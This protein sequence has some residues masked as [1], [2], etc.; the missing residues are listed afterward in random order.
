VRGL[1]QLCEALQRVSWREF[2]QRPRVIDEVGGDFGAGAEKGGRLDESHGEGEVETDERLRV[3]QMGRNDEGELRKVLKAQPDPHVCVGEVDFGHVDQ[4]LSGIDVYDDVEEA[5]E[6]AV[7]L[8]GLGRGL[9]LHS[10]IVATPRVVI[11]E[12][13]LAAGLGDAADRAKPDPGEVSGL[14]PREEANVPRRNLLG[15]FRADKVGGM[16]GGAVA[17]VGKGGREILDRG[18]RRASKPSRHFE[19]TRGKFHG[20]TGANFGKG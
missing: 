3:T 19:P 9:L 8:H 7:E 12:A 10:L 13:V 16:N 2:G 5:M 18:V 1:R 14:A 17:A 11:D 15:E 20:R 6:G 4:A